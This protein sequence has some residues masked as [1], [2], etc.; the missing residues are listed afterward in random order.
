MG[1][2]FWADVVVAVH[3]AYVSFVLLGQVAILV[4]VARKWGW[5]RNPWFRLAHL[6][7][8]SVVALEALAGLTCPLTEWEDYLRRVAGQEVTGGSFVGRALHRLIF[9]DCQPGVLAALHVGFA[10]LVLATFIWAPPR[11]RRS[12]LSRG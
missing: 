6:V 11:W 12:E 3:V 8:I 4:G 10:V 2:G 7:A 1:Y 5:V 9:Y